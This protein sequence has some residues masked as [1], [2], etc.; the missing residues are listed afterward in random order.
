MH[1]RKQSPCR[2]ERAGARM[3]FEYA[4]PDTIEEALQL[5]T[6][7]ARWI[8]GGTDLVQELKAGLADPSRLVNLKRLGGL[9]GIVSAEGDGPTSDGVE[10]GALTTLA[11][12]ASD[13]RI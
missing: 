10:I 4:S 7:R 8:A 2:R 12:I 5:V 13:A 3:P 9:R 1:S 6:G 11:E